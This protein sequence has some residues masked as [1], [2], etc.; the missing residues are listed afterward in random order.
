MSDLNLVINAARRDAS[1]TVLRNAYLLLAL[2]MIPT[3]LAA[4]F[5][6]GSG[7]TVFSNTHPLIACAGFLIVGIGLTALISA[8]KDSPLGVVFLLLFAAFS[9]FFI[10]PVLT[11]VLHNSANGAQTLAVAAGGTGIVLVVM[12]IAATVTRRDLS[13]MGA[14]LSAGLTMLIVATFANLFLGIHA[15]ELA[16]GTV[17][18]LVFAGYVLYDVNQAVRGG[19]T[20]SIV[21]ALNLYLDA[22]NLFLSILRILED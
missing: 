10:S 11:H 16:L 18:C 19:A 7:F 9:G 6:M 20:N 8:T 2:S 15:L 4:W 3:A 12:A 5:G 17:A 14:W 21:V 22:I 13:G 1:H